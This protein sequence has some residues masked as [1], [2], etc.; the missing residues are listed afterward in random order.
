[1]L[2]KTDIVIVMVSIFL[3]SSNAA[4]HHPTGGAGLGKTGPLRTISAS[5]LQPGMWAL[6]LQTEFIDLDAYSDDELMEIAE[7]GSDVHSVDSIHHTIFSMG[8]GLTSDLTVSL[9]IP[10]IIL[11]NIR[12]S[13]SDEP[14]EVHVHGDSEG[15][16][17]LTVF[18]QYRFIKLNDPDVE[19]SLVL[20]LRMPTGRTSVGDIDSE[21]FETEFQPGSGAWAPMA[22]I[23]ATKRFKALSLDADALYTFATEGT[24]KTNLG[25]LFNYDLAVS[26]TALSRPVVLDL[27]IEANGEWKQKQETDG[28]KDENSG[29]TVI[30]LSPGMRLSW[31]NNWAAYLSAGFPIAQNLNGD[32]NETDMRVLLGFSVG[33]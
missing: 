18:G 31:S 15:I 13:H 28:E 9:K 22:G 27:I 29:G 12:E 32:Q 33:L 14:E 17:D 21:P 1:M 11:N 8:Y 26:Y 10:Y 23:A 3:L 5:P 6:A 24:Q 16:G 7:S 30:F 2:K 20:G 19:S 25:D 4:A